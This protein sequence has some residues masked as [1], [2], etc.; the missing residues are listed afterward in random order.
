MRIMSETGIVAE[1]SDAGAAAATR[2]DQALARSQ[3]RPLLP[4]D[5]YLDREDSWVKFNQRV[6]EL[7][8]DERVPQLDRVRFL[9]LFASNLD[10]FFMVRV[11]A[12]TR[13]QVAGFPVEGASPML[14]SQI[15]QGTL[16]GA[17]ESMRRHA[18]VFQR[19]VRPALTAHGIEIIRW[20]DLEPAEQS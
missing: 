5:R 6:L 12:L 16:K 8:E 13:R 17:Q 2:A 15:L 14:P 7:A 18:E 20:K 9:A 1:I 11:A 10:E 3:A 4:P 19:L